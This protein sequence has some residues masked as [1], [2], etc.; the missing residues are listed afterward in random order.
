VLSKAE[1]SG[2]LGREV[3]SWQTLGLDPDRLYQLLRP[4]DEL[5]KGAASFNVISGEYRDPLR[6]IVF[7]TV[8]GRPGCVRGNRLRCA[9]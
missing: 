8:E 9:R 2:Y 5:Q 3:P 6:V 1:V 4:A 7:N